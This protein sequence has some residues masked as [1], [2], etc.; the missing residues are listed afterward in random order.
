MGKLLVELQCFEPIK[1]RIETC[2]LIH[3]VKETVPSLIGRLSEQKRAF[4]QLSAELRPI[5]D[6]CTGDAETDQLV[7]PAKLVQSDSEKVRQR[8]RAAL[9]PSPDWKIS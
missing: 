4:D 8:D 6:R 2:N 1:A 9:E 5:L 7:I 3:R